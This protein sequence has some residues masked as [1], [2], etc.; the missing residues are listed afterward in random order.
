MTKAKLDDNTVYLIDGSGYIF[1]AYFAVRSL[2]SKKG[3]P[4]NAVYGFTTM[5]LK[6]LR[7]HQPKLLAIAFDRKEPTF[8]HK[9][10]DG[11]KANRPEPPKDLVPQFDLIHQ[12][13][14]AFNIKRLSM[15][16]FEADD[17]IGTVAKK[18]RD[19]GHEV[20][21]VT[22]DKD[23]MQLVGDNIFLLDELRASR[24]GTEELINSQEVKNQLGVSPEQVIDLLA[25]AGDTSDNIPGVAG[26]GKKTAVELI[27]EFGPL[28]KILEMAPLIKQ[29]S[30]REKIIDG[31][32]MALLSKKL[33]Q[34]D[35]D[36]DIDCSLSDLK[37][38]GI[39]QKRAKELFTELDFSRLLH[40]KYLFSHASEHAS[41]SSKDANVDRSLYRSVC[42]TEELDKLLRDIAPVKKIAI[43]TETDNINAI[44]AHLIG[45][46][47]AWGDNNAAYIPV[48]HE[49]Q[50]IPSQIDEAYVKEKISLL[51]SDPNKIF[52]AQNAKYDYTVLL[53]NGY[54]N[55]AI[56]GDPMLQSYL[57]HQDNERHNLDDLSQKYLEH[58]TIKYQDITKSDKTSISFAQVD[59]KNATEY[60]AEDADL[61]L[62]L[63]KT[64]LSDVE[65]EKLS[66]LYFDVELPLE[67]VLAHMEI[68]GVKIDT[69]KLEILD[70]EL[71][72][73]LVSLEEKAYSLAEKPFNL[74]SPKQVGEIL[75]DHLKLPV[76]KK[77]KTGFSTDVSVLEKLS[78]AHELP[79]ILLEH[80]TC[81]KLINTYV[82]TLPKLI[83]ERTGRIHTSYNQFVTAT[84]R[85]SSSDP[86]LQNIPA[87]TAEG[88]RIRQAFIAEPGKVI[89]SLDYSQVELRLLA[90]V[91]QD[92]VLL[93][94]FAK[95]EDVHRR[96]ASEIFDVPT[97]EITKEQRSAAKTINFGLLYGMGVHKL[98]STLSIS[99][100]K[101]KSYLEK[102]FIKYA[103]ILRWKEQALAQAH[104]EKM[105]RTLFG[106]KRSLEELASSNKM[107]IARGERL[108]INTPI[109]GT[110]ADIIKKAMIDTDKFLQTYPDVHLIMQVHDELVIEAPKKDAPIIAEKVAQIMR[111]GHGLDVDLKVDFAIGDNWEA[112]H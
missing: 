76:V 82:N 51:L 11:Y 107:L 3:I 75:F 110:A 39:D 29:K 44:N 80:R 56:G 101:A 19:L 65:K 90:L 36:V 9:I 55:L 62:R 8:R 109:Q 42:R 73:Q 93:D 23:L 27:N 33:V 84:G 70:R 91:S 41:A 54:G 74:A 89:I 105:V 24:N 47:L 21:I 87:R 13:V 48:N 4:T 38:D 72:E 67:H 2:H 94:S 88:R 1:R 63:E 28:E 60:A 108:A 20:V 12:V 16:G 92:P 45:I 17:L 95:D 86:N 100:E 71:N 112:A 40:D 98:A 18:Y 31:H 35:C 34:I 79:K 46:S 26:I 43:D 61:A 30:R 69:H 78:E 6:L 81:S 106:R 7:E 5:L 37:Y 22:G 85:L 32:N 96:T 52:V 104:K 14:D 49:P 102:Y 68:Q 25:L 10:Y 15:A 57:L 97:D 58:K 59:L 83:N 77:T 66:K 111:H 50:A 53:L 103:G 64:L 99:R